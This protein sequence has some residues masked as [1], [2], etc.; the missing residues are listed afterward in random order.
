MKKINPRTED[1]LVSVGDLVNR[2]PDSAG[3]VDWAIENGVQT[4]LGNHE[5]RLLRAR[6]KPGKVQMK[7]YDH[8]TMRVLKTRHWRYLEKMPL[9]L[10]LPHWNAVVVHGGFLPGMPWREQTADVVTRIQVVTPDGRAAKRGECPQGRPWAEYWNGPEYV[11]YGH[12]PRP[13]P[14]LRKHS[15]GLD[16][17][18]VYGGQLTACVLPGRHLFQVDAL[19]ATQLYEI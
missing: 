15:V 16:T 19:P 7:S 2:G 11:L 1:T 17:G 5:A 13:W 18:C 9:M 14:M 10:D 12:T 3:V 6:A 8:D 4:V